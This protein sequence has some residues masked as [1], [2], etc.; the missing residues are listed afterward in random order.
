LV[1]SVGAH[2]LTAAIDA[3]EREPLQTATPWLALSLL[4][5]TK[6]ER[7]GDVV[8]D[9]TPYRE[10]LQHA[11]AALGRLSADE[12]QAAVLRPVD[13]HLDEER[14]QLVDTLAEQQ[15]ART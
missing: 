5:G 14:N 1:G 13:P 10:A 8:A 9:F 4:M 3:L 2:E 6:L 7:D 11:L 15:H 12:F